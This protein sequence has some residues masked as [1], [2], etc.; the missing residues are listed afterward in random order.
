MKEE[1][2][3][4]SKAEC[5]QLNLAHVARKVQKYNKETET[6]KRQCPLRSVQLTIRARQS[7]NQKCHNLSVNIFLSRYLHPHYSYNIAVWAYCSIRPLSSCSSSYYSY[8][9]PACNNRWHIKQWS[10]RH[11]C[12]TMSVVSRIDRAA[13]LENVEWL[14]LRNGSSDRLHVWIQDRLF[15]VGGMDVTTCWTKSKR[16]PHTIFKNFEWGSLEWV[17]R[18][19]FKKLRAT[20]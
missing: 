14:Y 11:L 13:I 2:D 15:S 10:R 7:R 4:D 19:T 5:G 3:V 9:W 12:N 20:L 18:S 6:N 16:R 8:R 17:I 1:F